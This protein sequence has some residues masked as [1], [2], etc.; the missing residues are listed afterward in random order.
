MVELKNLLLEIGT[1][2]LP[3]SCI[4][5]GISGLKSALEEKL[6][7]GRVVFSEVQTFATPR[8]IVA[9]VS[10]I[11]GKQQSREKVI[12]GPPKKIAFLPDGE[13]TE[14]ATGFAK[15]L[16]VDVS[17]LQEIDNG[18]GIYMGLKVMEESRPVEEVLPGLLKDTI[19]SLSFSK[20]MTW[21]DLDIKFARP[22]RWLVAIYGGKTLK[23]N[24]ENI[25]SS[26]IS[27]GIRSYSMQP[28]KIPE[29]KT[30][31]DYFSFL[32]KKCGVILDPTRRRKII[33]DYIK[34]IET[35]KWKNRLRVVVDQELL[36]EVVNLVEIPNVLVGSFPD[37]Y[38]YMPS[39]ILIKAIQHHQR[40]FAVMEKSRKVAPSFVVVQNG[41]EDR[42]DDVINGNERVLRARLSDARF[43]YE[44]DRKHDFDFWYKKLKGVIFYYGL[45]SMQDRSA[46]LTKNCIETLKM[47]EGKSGKKIETSIDDLSRAS[48]LCKCDLVTN[49]V[50]EFPEL[51]GLV[52]MEYAKEKG[53]KK[54]VAR[55]V[56]EHYLPRFS[57]DMLPGT[58]TGSILSIAD[59]IDTITGMFLVDNRPS[60]SQDPFA[61]RRKASGIILTALEKDFDLDIK[62]LAGFSLDE[63]LK[64]FDFKKTD[65]EKLLR[66]ITDFI[67]ARYRFRLEKS[68]KR[69]DLFD[70]IVSSGCYSIIE[71]NRRYRAMEEY[72][73]QKDIIK[74]ISEPFTR[75][76]NIIKG[77][78]FSEI[79]KG[80]LMEDSEKELH[81]TLM[82]KTK[83][84]PGAISKRNYGDALEGLED[85]GRYI[86]DFFDNVL[87]MEKDEKLRS[88]RI[89]LV[90][91]CADLYLLFAD[92]SRIS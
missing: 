88:N 30:L 33:L 92:F 3:S 75:C 39:E 7:E 61:L 34:E 80:L 18:N 9:F 31:D 79:R 64:G 47:L 12:T 70:S 67:I 27:F 44:E 19:L 43:F 49:L 10:G 66:D 68:S 54:D 42:N 69:L 15:S 11:K 52:G 41:I 35:R 90:K 24:I 57:G 86:N 85:F 63:Y 73:G 53:E 21:G 23:F 26:D 36:D 20:Q 8:R 32:E 45:G 60:G 89:N 65:R 1:E 81:K 78:E 74:N 59:K 17:K 25:Y 5:E 55:A 62:R 4:Q 2:E 14:A 46:R 50:V 48:I 82:K 87:V 37:E 84:I 76:K 13:P 58:D 83:A 71:I 72:T 22:I 6:V 16:K 28:V 56:F 91:A 29:I 77:R 38:L 51:Q 40:Y